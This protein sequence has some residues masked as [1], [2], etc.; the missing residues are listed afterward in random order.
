MRDY[1]SCAIPDDSMIITD[2]EPKRK[3]DKISTFLS[4]WMLY[5]CQSEK[6]EDAIID[7]LAASITPRKEVMKS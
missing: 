7:T 1:S 6:G 2:F 4:I 3:F 5:I